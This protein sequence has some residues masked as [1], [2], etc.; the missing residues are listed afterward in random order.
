MTS[1]AT[2]DGRPLEARDVAV[3]VESHKDARACYRA[4]CD[5]GIPAV[6]TGDSDIFNSDAAETGCAAG[7]LR[8]AAPARHG[9]AAAATM[10]FGRTADELWPAA[11]H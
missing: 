3:I 9:A 4:L 2:F 5:A 10:F 11:T 1:E 8:S 6:Y 7:S